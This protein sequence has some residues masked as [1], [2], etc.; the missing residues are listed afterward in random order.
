MSKHNYLHVPEIKPKIWSTHNVQLKIADNPS[1][2]I[3]QLEAIHGPAFLH[4][5]QTLLHVASH[6]HEKSLAWKTYPVMDPDSLVIWILPNGPF[7]PGVSFD[8]FWCWIWQGL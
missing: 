3:I 7:A 4:N 1:V 6:L 5:V 8:G 2:I